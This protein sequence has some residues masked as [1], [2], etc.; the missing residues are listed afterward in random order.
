MEKNA[1]IDELPGFSPLTLSGLYPGL[2]EGT[3]ASHRYVC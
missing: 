2:V 1:K 3:T